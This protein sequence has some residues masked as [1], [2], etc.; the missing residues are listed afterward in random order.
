[1]QLIVPV[2]GHPTCPNIASSCLEAES[3]CMKETFA[4]AQLIDV[5]Y[6]FVNQLW[7]LCTMGFLLLSELRGFHESTRTYR[8]LVIRNAVFGI[9]SESRVYDRLRRGFKRSGLRIAIDQ[10][11]YRQQSTHLGF[12]ARICLIAHRLNHSKL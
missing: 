1:M 4:S 10:P 6:R 5:P 2:S 12:S 3:A 7:T 11:L 8:N 9:V